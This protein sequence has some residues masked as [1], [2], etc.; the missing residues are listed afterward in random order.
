MVPG[1]ALA[2]WSGPEG[3]SLV[4]YRTLPIPGGGTPEMIT[5]ALANRLMN[6]PELKLLSRRVESLTGATAGRVEVVAPG[7]GDSLAPSGIGSPIAIDGKELI[8]TRQITL[9]IPRASGPLYV[10]CHVP[11]SAFAQV[12]PEIETAFRSLKLSPDTGSSSDSYT[13]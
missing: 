2:A 3:S 5:E 6:L 11:E 13:D 9:G 1:R 12:A 10:T 4:V 7:F 8:P